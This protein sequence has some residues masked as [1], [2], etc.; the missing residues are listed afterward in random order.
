MIKEVYNHV[1]GET[2][3]YDCTYDENGN[4]IKKICTYSSGK[5]ETIDVQYRFVY[6]PYELSEEI[7]ELFLVWELYG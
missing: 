7:E 5:T 6:I 3:N 2:R 1:G 4:L